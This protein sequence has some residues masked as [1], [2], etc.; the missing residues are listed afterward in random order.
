M[1]LVK[2]SEGLWKKLGGKEKRR[3]QYIVYLHEILKE[4]IVF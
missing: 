4:K 2:G 3:Y 1:K